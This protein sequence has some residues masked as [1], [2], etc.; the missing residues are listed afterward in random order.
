MECYDFVKKGSSLQ[1]MSKGGVLLVQSF[2]I[3][4]QV[5]LKR[6]S[7]HLHSSNVEVT[8]S[9]GPL[10]RYSQSVSSLM[11]S[12]H[13]LGVNCCMVLYEAVFARSFQDASVELP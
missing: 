9:V 12:E 3:G 7:T 10:L 13:V 1:L 11:S 6:Q 5:F 4:L 2:E 8:C